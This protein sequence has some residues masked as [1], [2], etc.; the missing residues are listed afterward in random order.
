MPGP[1]AR[2]GPSSD[3]RQPAAPGDALELL[4]TGAI[5]T[6]GLMPRASNYTFLV[7]IRSGDVQLLAVYKPRRGERPLWDFPAGTLA[8]REVAAYVVSEALGWEV[9]PPTVLRDGPQGL[10]MVQ[11]YIHADPQQ[12]YFTLGKQF[13]QEFRRL[14]VF[15]ALINNADRKAGHCLRD[16]NGH[17]WGID[18]GV[19]F[20]EEPK[21]RTVIWQYAG[22]RIP[23]DQIRDVRALSDRL[24]SDSDPVT[25]ALRRL[26][27]LREVAALA[28]R[29]GLLIEE[30]RFPVPDRYERHIP[31][32]PV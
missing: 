3:P 25:E 6:Q 11:L 20:H 17:V 29:A 13:P 32:P 14:A 15:D 18:H 9:V 24:K 16:E 8:Q 26:L 22:S 21:L 28:K 1:D 10:G 30:A 27:T 23:A 2:A 5:E 7:I 31:W 4:A 19:C 12:N